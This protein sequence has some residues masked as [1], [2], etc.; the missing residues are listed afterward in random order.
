MKVLACAHLKGGVGKTTTAVNLAHEAVDAGA[1]V[2]LWDLDPQAAA[3]WLVRVRPKMSGG[4]RRLVGTSGALAPHVRESDHPGL[5][6]VP[7]DFSLR[8]LDVHLDDVRRPRRRILDLLDP[9]ADHYDLV[10][11]DCAPGLTLTTEAVFRAADV[12]LVPTI[13]SSLSVRT[14]DQLDDFLAGVDDDR[15]PTLVPFGSMVDRRRRL[16]RTLVDQLRTS[17]PTTLTTSI[18]ASSV[19]ERMGVERAPV[20]SFAPRSVAAQAYRDLWAEVA[21]LL[22]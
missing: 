16:H 8:H 11:L 3:T 2:L 22:W 13:P 21:A 4:A 12:L 9:I 10:V 20:R 17:F 6:L 15:R 7:A 14:L 18:P 19:I 1:R 5:H